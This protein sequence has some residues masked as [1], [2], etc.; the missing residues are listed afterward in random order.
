MKL[1][2][3]KLNLLALDNPKMQKQAEELGYIMA[4]L[5]LA[6]HK[7][8]SDKTVCPNAHKADCFAHCLYFSGNGGMYKHVKEARIRKTNLFHNERELF[9]TMLW[10]DLSLLQAVSK[11]KEMKLAIRLNV[12][13]DINWM[14]IKHNGMNVFH[15]FPD[16]Q[17]YDYTKVPQ[18]PEKL[19]PNYSLTFSY[20]PALAY[21]STVKRA[22]SYKMNMTVVFRLNKGESLPALWNGKPVID[23]DKNDMRFLDPL[24]VVIGLKEKRVTDKVQAL[25]KRQGLAV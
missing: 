23:G 14:A 11:Q 16:I 6:P 12:L 18:R 15:A 19:P 8:A 1:S 22:M 3:I 17:F 24:G 21:Q 25:D 7:A 2:S 20:S 13:S 4:G 10:S 9:L 5:S